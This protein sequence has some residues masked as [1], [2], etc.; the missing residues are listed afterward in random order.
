MSKNIWY[1][2]K[3]ANC[4]KYGANSR[5]FSFS[6]EFVKKGNCV[7]LIIGNSSHLFPILPKFSGDF[8]LEKID[9]VDIV[10]I[11]L[12]K[13]SKAT[14][15]KRFWT[16]V[17]FEYKIIKNHKKFP[18]FKPDTVI[19]SSL[20]IL[21]IFSGLFLKKTCKCKF[22]LEVRDIWPQSFV[23][24]RA[25]SKKGLI[26]YIL[27]LIEK[28]GYKYSDEI[29]GTMP[30]LYLHVKE[31]GFNPNKVTC[32]PQGFDEDFYSKNQEVIN[33][34]Y[35]SK[36]LPKNKFT[37]TYAGT[38]GVSY[39]LNKVVEAATILEKVEPSI[40]FVFLGDG[41]EENKLKQQAKGLSN[42]TFAP[43]VRKE[44][45][46]SFLSK[47]S[48]LLHSFQTKKVFE[49]GISPNKFIDYM[50]SGR[51]SIVMFSGYKSLINDAGCG[52]F[53]EA[54]NTKALSDKIIEY[55]KKNKKELIIIG[56]NGKRYLEQNLTYDILAKKYL[57][58]IL[59][60][61]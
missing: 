31:S 15:I 21:S 59:N 12:P 28:I 3:Y 57:N 50:Y 30:G 22:I 26:Y 43:R 35:I 44:Q 47:S 5:Q 17:L 56:E 60:Y 8:F 1:I 25:S 55:S 39:A 38:L 19:A 58:I 36:Y 52:E 45:V 20:S 42:V 14:S 4:L 10:W 2:S 9:D 13:Y 11:N 37:I 51:P 61:E 48:L 46:L 16:W 53:V 7:S 24:L 33:E 6:K 32:V 41:I 29:V 23:D 54:E 27:R 34:D 49:Y 18:N 40:H